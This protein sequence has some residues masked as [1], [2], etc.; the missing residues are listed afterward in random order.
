MRT[1][2]IICLLL[3][4]I[5]H[6][7][8]DTFTV[9]TTSEGGVCNATTCTLRG[10]IN[11]A[12]V[13]PGDDTI[14]FDIPADPVN[15]NYF[16]G[17]TGQDAFQYWVIQPTSELPS[18]IDITIDGSTAGA[19]VV[20]NPT[21]V[22]DGSL[23]G[24]SNAGTWDTLDGL[25]LLGNTHINK[26]AFINWFNA[27][28]RFG[29]FQPNGIPPSSNNRLTGS[30]LGLSIP[31]GQ[32]SAPNKYGIIFTTE[33]GTNNIVG[34]NMST[35]GN[36]ISGNLQ[37]GIHFNY[38][39][40]NGSVGVFGNKIGTN[41][42]GDL[43][44][45]NDSTGIILST[46]E[47][48][49]IIIGNELPGLGNLISGNNINGIHVTTSDYEMNLVID[50]N[51]IG[52]DITGLTALPNRE[53]IQLSRGRNMVVKNN[54]ISGSTGVAELILSTD[55]GNPLRNVDI[56]NNYIGVGI[57][58]VT[59]ISNTSRGVYASGI[60]INTKIGA[61]GQGNVIAN[62]FCGPTSGCGVV[63][64]NYSNNVIELR[65]NSIY[66]NE[67][68]GIDLEADRFTFNDPGDFDSGANR[69]QNFPEINNAAHDP[70]GNR[71]N[72]NYWID[73]HYAA[74][75]YPITVDIYAADNDGEEGKTW[76]AST[77]FSQSQYIVGNPVIRTLTS[78]AAIAEGDVIVTTA[79]DA[80]GRT[81]EF[82]PGFTLAGQPD[83]SIACQHKKITS[84]PALS[85]TIS[86]EAEAV[87]GWG[88]EVGMLCTHAD[89]NCSFSPSEEISFGQGELVPFSVTIDHTSVTP[90]IYLNE[91]LGSVP[92][93]GDPI[94]RAEVITIHQ[95]ADD[96]YL[97]V[98]G[99]DGII[100][101]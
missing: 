24:D 51:L 53:G 8:A 60:A 9:N 67:N 71:I 41:P 17:G 5:T 2:A 28:I 74:S 97:F 91:V 93:Q 42:Q 85:C 35:E 82:S 63:I 62:N 81:S 70:D 14:V 18:L 98:D 88:D 57:D 64:S 10:A 3:T 11:A 4:T 54:V 44:V 68:E 37:Y 59:P 66:N 22:I 100:C 38:Y 80:G 34:G 56:F 94:E 23:A 25:T 90:G 6:V 31:Y 26:L 15:E 96:D 99:F 72:F 49:N 65:Y 13:T 29:Y 58:G 78:Q 27:G 1:T 16:S 95:L 79:T 45:P 73:S 39:L 52:T 30:W 33:S 12:L 40:R 76:L 32:A 101:H 86:C 92:T 61:P 77:T 75:D 19:S 47:N 43:A 46:Q 87:N 83:F 20:G 69:L 50:G 21:I 7:Y 55:P 36:I 48:S 84:S 89:S